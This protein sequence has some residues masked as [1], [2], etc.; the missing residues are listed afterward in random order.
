VNGETERIV[1]I[2]ELNMNNVRTTAAPK[3]LSDKLNILR[4]IPWPHLAT[5]QLE[6]T[7][8]SRGEKSDGR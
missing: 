4:K 2:K 5:R 7:N 6:G 8:I 3:Y 1:V